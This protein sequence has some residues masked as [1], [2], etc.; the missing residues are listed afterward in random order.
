MQSVAPAGTLGVL[1]GLHSRLDAHFRGLHA[2]RAALG[3]NAPVFAL[4]HD[5]NCPDLELLQT[6]VR[7][8]VTQGFRTHHR[9]WWLPFVVYAAE[10]GYGY[11][12]KEYWQT[13]EEQTPMWIHFGDRDRIRGFFR[14]FAEVYGGVVPR[15]AFASNFTIIAWPI[16]N[17]V[18]PIS[19]QRDLAHLLFEFQRALTPE[20]LAD[21]EALGRRL[22][23][24]ADGYTEQFRI[25]CSS[26]TLL[27]SV[28]AALLSGEGEDSPYLSSSTLTR[29]VDSLSSE[30]ESRRWLK[31]VRH[32]AS[33]V[34]ARGFVRRATP[35][36]RPAMAKR[37]PKTTDPRLLFTRQEGLW[38]AWVAL[39][40]LSQLAG[41]SSAYEEMR[42]RRALVDGAAGAPLARGRLLYPGQEVRLAKWPRPDAAFIQLEKGTSGVNQLLAARCLITAGPAWLFR[43]AKSG[44]AVEVKTKVVRPGNTYLLVVRGDLPAPE[45]DWMAAVETDTAGI[46]LFSFELPNNI[47]QEA[48]SALEQLGLA[49]ITDVRIR[50]VG[51]VAAAWDGEGSIEWRAGE[52]AILGITS[53]LEAQSCLV[54]IDGVQHSVQWPTGRP[55]L[56]LVLGDLDIGVHEV[57][58]TL[59]AADTRP[60]VKECVVVTI[61]DPQVRPDGA[62]TAEGI[63]LLTSPARPSLSDLFDQRAVLTVD[64]P[65]GTRVDTRVTLHSGSGQVLTE[66]R[67]SLELPVSAEEWAEVV[68]RIRTDPTFQTSYDAA[69]SARV[70]AAHA[71]IGFAS[72]TCDRGFKPLRWCVS[73]RHDGNQ[74]ARLIDRTDQA[75]TIVEMFT[76]EEPLVPIRCTPD[77]DIPLPE[78]GGLLR[79]TA[80]DTQESILVPTQP[81]KVLQSG[82][83]RPKLSLAGRTTGE[84]MKLIEGAN[85]W[86]TAELPGDP[87]ASRQQSVV[88]D[89]IT[90]ALVSGIAGSHWANLEHRLVDTDQ[91]I[92]HLDD[93]H[94]A[95]GLSPDQQEI[96][97]KIAAHL[98]EWMEPGAML[99]GF[100]RLIDPVLRRSGIADVP[101]AARFLLLFAGRPWCLASWS[102]ASRDAL[103]RGITISP[104]L[105]RAARFAVLG[106]RALNDAEEAERGF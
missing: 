26:T 86:A 29:L 2:A 58:I 78:L 66:T 10:S 22:S 41:E 99:A 89:A 52:P 63:R 34:R 93:M 83:L 49:V 3:G 7:S 70:V 100:A 61:R 53:Q 62:T 27:G 71:G 11:T 51:L 88:L 90:R 14:K 13:F 106:A 44:P 64:G 38:R 36:A 75:A 91:V 48:A 67:R 24:R 60:L 72:L 92:D 32:V 65:A 73:P 46:R 81:T 21:P 68:E 30:R 23:A 69:E 18:L 98:W 74:I 5:L 95:I 47:S 19:L 20:L 82:V 35:A 105:V 12:G 6:A 50:P 54:A 42:G 31:S 84:I 25:F 103:L 102:S 4:E 40:D 33:R 94:D 85:A 15:G 43:Q 96:A 59:L 87:F 79:A 57:G 56:F 55:D 8:A 9:K 16:A 1:E 80:R 77:E 101:A 97:D 76:V 45:V 39:P 28:A 104:V 37:L 17:A